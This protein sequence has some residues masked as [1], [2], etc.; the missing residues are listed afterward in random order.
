MR[1]TLNHQHSQAPGLLQNEGGKLNKKK[2]YCIIVFL[3]YTH[4]HT[5]TQA[6]MHV[7]TNQTNSKA[8][9]NPR[10]MRSVSLYNLP[11]SSLQ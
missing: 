3:L 11:M 8:M 5:C 7:H 6:D 10:A 4:T 1:L 9:I 2:P